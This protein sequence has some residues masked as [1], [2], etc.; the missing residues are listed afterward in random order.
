MY[1][2]KLLEWKKLLYLNAIHKERKINCKKY[3]FI[4]YFLKFSSSPLI[5]VS[6]GTWVDRKNTKWF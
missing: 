5:E 2:E 3:K 1:F 4:I 6:S